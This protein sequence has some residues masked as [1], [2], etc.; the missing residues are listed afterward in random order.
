M[1]RAPRDSSPRR[2]DILNVMVRKT[3]G[4]QE[5]RR[6]LL[7]RAGSLSCALPADDVVRV[8]RS[9]VC[10]PI[11]GSEPRL[12]GL[13]QY[14]GEPLPV[15]DLQA[16]VDSSLSGLR[17]RSTVIVGRCRRRDRQILGLAVDEV[18][19]VVHI[20]GITRS[21]EE[22][23]LVVDAEVDGELVKV[24]DTRRLLL[25]TGDDTGAMDG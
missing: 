19:R 6:C 12:Q 20:A 3:P 8:V 22:A 21:D 23:G 7:V 16:L 4:R 17:H 25:D 24:V 2:G 15:L 18:V 10:Y 5:D 9:L 14:G 1:K 11:P 13:A